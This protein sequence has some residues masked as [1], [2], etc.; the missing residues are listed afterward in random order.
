MPKTRGSVRTTLPTVASSG[1]AIGIVI[2][3]ANGAEV[4]AIFAQGDP[5]AVVESFERDGAAIDG[6]SKGCVHIELLLRDNPV[7]THPQGQ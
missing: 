5:D 2:D 6:E 3:Q 1:H 4:V 7:V